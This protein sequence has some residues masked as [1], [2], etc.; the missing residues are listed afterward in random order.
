MLITTCCLTPYQLA[1]DTDGQNL[2]T[3][4]IDSSINFCFFLDIFVNFTSAYYDSDY[5]LI[6]EHRVRC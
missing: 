6:E 5:N 1:F 3:L 2:V 4:G